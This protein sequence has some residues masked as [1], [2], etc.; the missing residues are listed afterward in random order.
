MSQIANMDSKDISVMPT[1][2]GEKGVRDDGD[3]SIHMDSTS[4]GQHRGGTSPAPANG[5]SSKKVP[6]A[7]QSY[8]PHAPKR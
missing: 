3:K 7:D 8:A 1:V 2:H 5:Q 4:D 6:G